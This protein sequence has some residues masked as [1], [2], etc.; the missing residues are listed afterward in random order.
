MNAYLFFLFV[1]TPL[2]HVLYCGLTLSSWTA[3]DFAEVPISSHAAAATSIWPN[4]SH[5]KAELLIN[6]HPKNTKPTMQELARIIVSPRRPQ[7]TRY[8]GPKSR[9]TQRVNL[10][11]DAS[12]HC[13]RHGCGFSN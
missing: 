10:R 6:E 2:I 5:A 8:S 4:P 13:S 12:E 3:L 11:Q 1:E 9:S 7:E